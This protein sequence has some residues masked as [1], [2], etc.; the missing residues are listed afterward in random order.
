M[1]LAIQS[2]NIPKEYG[3]TDAKLA[4]LAAKYK[5]LQEIKDPASRAMAAGGRRECRE[6]R[7]AV[8]HKR[9]E[10][11]A[12]A[13]EFGRRVDG[14]AKRITESLREIEDP[15][16]ALIKADETRR[17]E[18]RQAKLRV[19]AEAEAKER[20]RVDEIKGRIESRYGDSALLSLH[21]LPSQ[22]ILER[23]QQEEVITEA[24]GFAE[25]AEEAR[26]RQIEF[27]DKA[28]EL[29]GAKAEAEAEAER[30]RL[31]A[32]KL[33]EERRQFEEEQRLAREK[34]EAEQTARQ[35]K[36]RQEREERERSESALQARIREERESI[37]AERR[38]LREEQEAMEAEKRRIEEESLAKIRAEDEEKRRQEMQEQARL[39]A[40]QDLKERQE[41]EERER[42]AREEAERMA[43]EREEMLKPDQEKIQSFALD[44]LAVKWPV[45]T[46]PEGQRAMERIK[47][48]IS[49][50]V[51]Y[52]AQLADKLAVEDPE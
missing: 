17:E 42:L 38:Q 29:H 11:K 15:L 32:E 40:E 10:L 33:A 3:V 8:E 19:I 44:L 48:K 34:A 50:V 4:E 30:Q 35:E 20:A 14:E 6:L 45:L 27:T 43:K 9:K 25:F 18:E 41:R 12:D 37:E 5:D 2:I 47:K 26:R 52:A 24:D 36:E 13:L 46:T 16:D 28:G 51:D 7:V 49:A 31:E 21:S 23:I 39:C 22:G 1:D